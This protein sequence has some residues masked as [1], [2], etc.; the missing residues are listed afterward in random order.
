[1]IIVEVFKKAFWVDCLISLFSFMMS[2]FD[3][4]YLHPTIFIEVY[5]NAFWVEGIIS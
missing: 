1:M 3:D 4:S 2:L 5:K